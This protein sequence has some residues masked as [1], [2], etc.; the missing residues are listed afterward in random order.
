MQVLVVS[1]RRPA[2]FDALGTHRGAECVLWPGYVTQYGY[3]AVHLRKGP[4]GAVLVHRVAWERANGPIP[5]DL[6][7]DHKCSVRSCVNVDHLQLVTAGENTILGFTRA[8]GRDARRFCKNG[9]EW[10]PANTY[11][12]RSGYRQCRACVADVQRR[13]SNER[14]RE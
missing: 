8:S 14:R 1:G 2:M 3:G 6:V 7:I 13:R 12:R 10:T 5:D 11:I 4:G 9:H